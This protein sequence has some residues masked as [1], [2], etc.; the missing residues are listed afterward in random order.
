MG[1]RTGRR[2]EFVEDFEAAFK[3]VLG[4]GRD[5]KYLENRVGRVK[6]V[7]SSSGGVLWGKLR[8]VP[9]ILVAP[10]FLHRENERCSS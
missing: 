8:S 4:M 7:S 3:R 10:S 2:E 5:V 6:S 1:G 9:G